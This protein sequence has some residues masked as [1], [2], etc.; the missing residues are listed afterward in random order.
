[1]A[2]Q[3]QYSPA[4]DSEKVAHPTGTALGRPPGSGRKA[5][6]IYA[7]LPE[8]ARTTGSM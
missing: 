3:V 7:R 4:A 6:D 5:A 8:L 2:R 1:M